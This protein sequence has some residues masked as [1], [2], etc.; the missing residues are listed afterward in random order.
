MALDAT[1][2]LKAATGWYKSRLLL[3]EMEVTFNESCSILPVINHFR[4]TSLIVK[5]GDAKIDTS[6]HC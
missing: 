5:L 2:R 3:Q 6:R 1:G 4:Q